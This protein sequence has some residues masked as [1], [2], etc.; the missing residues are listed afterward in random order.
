MNSEIELTILMPCLNESETIELCIVKAMQFLNETKIIGEV[1]IADNGST[2]GSQRIATTAGARVVNVP[3]RGYGSAL[4]G[5]I[6]SAR[7]VYV[8]MG[9]ADDSYDFSKLHSFI[10]ELRNGNDLVMGNRFKGGIS[11]GAMPLLHKYLG[12]PV[13][14]FIGR[15]FFK[16]TIGDFHCGLRGFKK[17]SIIDLELKTTGMEFA[18]EVV[19]RSVLGGLKIAE[20]PT[21]LKKDGRT[22]PPHLRTWR[23]GW[24]HLR[25]LLIYSPKWL[26]MY[27]GLIISLISFF[28]FLSTEFN[29]SY[30]RGVQFGPNAFMVSFGGILGGIQTMSFYIFIRTFADKNKFIHEDSVFQKF[31][32]KFT[33]EKVALTSLFSIGIGIIL[34]F[35]GFN[36][37]SSKKFGQL[38]SIDEMRIIAPS[39]LMILLSIQIFF[40]RIFISILTV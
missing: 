40:T 4:I 32:S 19:V 22:R 14:S 12:N 38:S 20:V 8:I 7:G 15:L 9:D 37:W 35:Y 24:R 17:S 30:V 6:K 13:L 39:I 33:L 18:S 16:T 3:E 31:L 1:L 2:D 27:P 34:F 29:F 25:F 10:Y 11:K 26:F 28:I 21:T 36:V 23:D 5:G